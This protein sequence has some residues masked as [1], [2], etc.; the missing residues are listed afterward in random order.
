MFITCDPLHI[1]PMCVPECL[2]VLV[3]ID[4][5]YSLNCPGDPRSRLDIGPRVYLKFDFYKNDQHFHEFF[6][7][8]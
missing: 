8:F 2:R 3:K 6:Y 4:F 7:T 1:Q 5:N